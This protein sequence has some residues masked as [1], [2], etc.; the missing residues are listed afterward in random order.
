MPS[1]MQDWAASLGL[2]HQGVLVAAV[3]GADE[4]Q[5]DDPSKWLSRFY[6]ACV[7]RAHVGDPRKAASFMVWTDEGD[8]FWER[9]N[10]FIKSHDHYP[11][12]YL[13]HM[14]HAAEILGFYYGGENTAPVRGWW[15]DFYYIM[16][17]K[18]HMNPETKAQL[19]ARLNATE[20]AFALRDQ[21]EG[22]KV[23]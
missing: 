22:S 18:L 23:D 10:T 7:L 1:I 16:C 4:V 6:R 11:H 20:Q 17:D 14:I 12:H 3:R 9:A 8:E 2:R 21:I 5:R 13:M 15:R 19:D